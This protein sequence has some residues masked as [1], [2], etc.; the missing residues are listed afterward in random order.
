CRHDKTRC[1]DTRPCGHCR[2]KGRTAEQCVD[3][4]EACRQAR[5]RCEGGPP[6]T[7]CMSMHLNCVDGTTPP[8][9]ATLHLREAGGGGG[10]G[11]AQLACKSC[12]RGNKKCEDQRPCRRCVLHGD[13]CI[14]VVRRLHRVKV[15]CRS[16]REAH[17]R[18]EDARPCYYCSAGGEACVDLPRKGRGHGLRVKAACV[19]CREHKVRCDGQ[20]PCASCDRK[21]FV[22]QDTTGP[23]S[24]G[25]PGAVSPSRSSLDVNSTR[26]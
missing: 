16:C 20:R 3:G 14:P 17:R 7:R 24:T 26:F 2:K 13:E 6:C 19:K 1:D 8:L 9:A 22:C 10:G 5:A 12:Y 23:S 25:K 4:C 21:G 11:R 15:R 18:C